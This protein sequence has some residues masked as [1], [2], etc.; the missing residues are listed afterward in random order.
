MANYL[1]I[2]L[3]IGVISALAA[4]IRN[5]KSKN[6]S[7]AEEIRSLLQKPK[8]WQDLLADYIGTFLAIFLATALWPAFLIWLGY[9][10]IENK[11][12][13]ASND[14]PTFHSSPE[15]LLQQFTPLAAEQSVHI[16]QPPDYKIIGVFGHLEPGWIN[17]LSQI[18]SDDEIWSFCIPKDSPTKYYGK[19]AEGNIRGFAQLRKKKIVNEFIYEY[20]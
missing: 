16:T 18:E 10:A 15:Y 2:Y 19:T 6:S 4:Y 20:D 3:L 14:E 17:F 12:Q 7:F 8:N 13:V 11:R 9:Q 1:I 5:N